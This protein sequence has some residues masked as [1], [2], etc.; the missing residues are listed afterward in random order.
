MLVAFVIFVM[1]IIL[2]IFVCV[3]VPTAHVD[4]ESPLNFVMFRSP[5]QG[6]Y[7][8][9]LVNLWIRK[10]WRT[11]DAKIPCRFESGYPS[12]VPVSNRKLVL[13]SHGN[14]EDLMS[15]TFFL[16][17]L[18][19]KLQMDAVTWDYSGYGLN[20]LD[21]FERTVDGLNLSLK[22]VLDHMVTSGYKMSNIILWGYSLGTGP[23]TSLAG[24]ICRNNEPTNS[25]M[26]LILFGAYS[27]IIDVVKDHAAPVADIFSERWNNKVAITT[28][29]C[30]VLLMHGQSDGLIS[31]KHSMKLKD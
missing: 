5:G 1:A 7:S 12:N 24:S 6:R 3:F 29:K 18:S 13:Y 16:Q 20:P 15:C 9:Q 2:L 26:G 19:D 10:S 30:P 11:D 31:F 17:E 21:K 4:A 22:T 28:V 27:S 25:L 14:A 23:S 8:E